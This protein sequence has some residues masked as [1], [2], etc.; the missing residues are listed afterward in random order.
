[1][2]F[3]PQQPHISLRRWQGQGINP[4][5]PEFKPMPWNDGMESLKKYRAFLEDENIAVSLKTP[6]DLYD[7]ID[8][9]L[10]CFMGYE[11]SDIATMYDIDPGLVEQWFNVYKA[12]FGTV[13]YSNNCYSYVRN[14]PSKKLPGS[15]PHV[16]YL[17]NTKPPKTTDDLLHA[18]E[19][20]DLIFVGM[21]M[22]CLRDDFYTVALFIEPSSRSNEFTDFHWMG[23]NRPQTFSQKI[24]FG[25]A[26]DGTDMGAKIIRPHEI[27]IPG[28]RFQGYFYVPSSLRM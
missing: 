5:A 25:P 14:D 24:G 1:M 11:D 26:R 13:Q 3:R 6:Q 2:A 19:E 16:G 4:S 12:C 10:Y 23:E 28:Y 17:S 15:K 27:E 22:P 9:M 7:H 8:E 21:A 20:D 18:A